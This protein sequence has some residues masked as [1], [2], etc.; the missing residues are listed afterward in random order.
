MCMNAVVTGL[1]FAEIENQG[2]VAHSCSWCTLH[3]RCTCL[4]YAQHVCDCHGTVPL[5]VFVKAATVTAWSQSSSLIRLRLK[6]FE[7]RCVELLHACRA[8]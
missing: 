2:F 7:N 3:V 8:S 1:L 6:M 5:S 4:Q